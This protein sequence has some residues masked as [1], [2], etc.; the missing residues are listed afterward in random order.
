M[1]MGMVRRNCWI[2]SQ[3]SAFIMEYTGF[4]P[5]ASTM[6]MLRAPNCANTPYIIISGSRSFGFPYGNNGARTHDL[7]LVRRALSQLSYVSIF[8][9]SIAA[10][11]FRLRNRE[12][13]WRESNPRPKTHPMYFYYHS[14]FF[15]IPSAAR[16]R[17]SLQVQ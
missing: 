5:V 4:E 13:S 1:I 16:K 6:R 3:S 9:K 8:V 15:F 11:V 2:Q 7:P 17:T 10:S 12:W 14:P